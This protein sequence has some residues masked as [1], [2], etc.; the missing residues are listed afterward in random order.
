MD[1]VA[2]HIHGIFERAEDEKRAREFKALDR[3]EL[4]RMDDKTLAD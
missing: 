2:Q 4:A 1:V 3:R